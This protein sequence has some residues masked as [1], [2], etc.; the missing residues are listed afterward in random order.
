[1]IGDHCLDGACTNHVCEQCPSRD[2]GRCHPPGTCSQSDY[3]SRRRDKEAACSRPFNSDSF[4]GDKKVDCGALGALCN[5]AQAC[6]RAREI[7]QQCFRG[8]DTRHMEELNTVRESAQKC[9][10]LLSEKR[11]KKLCE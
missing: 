5:N 10:D 1:M 11:A 3:D 2:D 8:G 4:K 6:V 7:V 9:E